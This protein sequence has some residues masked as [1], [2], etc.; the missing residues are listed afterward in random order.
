MAN[1]KLHGKMDFQ[2]LEISVENRA[3]SVRSGVDKDGHKW[4]TKMKGAHYGRIVAV[5][6]KGSD[7]EHVDVFV[8]V[9]P[10]KGSQVFIVHIN[11]ADTGK[12]DEDKGFLGFGSKKE[13]KAAFD[14][15]YDKAGRK[16][17]GGMT[18][19]DMS[20]FKQRLE[21]KSRQMIKSL[22]SDHLR[23]R[24]CH[25]FNPL[26]VYCRLRDCGLPVKAAKALGRFYEEKI[27]KKILAGPEAER[28]VKAFEA[29]EKAHIRGY[30]RKTGS[31]RVVFVK[32]HG[33]SRQTQ[34]PQNS[35][36]PLLDYK[37]TNELARIFQ[38]EFVK[39]E[40]K[41]PHGNQVVFEPRN[42]MH[43]SKMDTGRA[44]EYRCKRM[45]WI[46]D[47]IQSPDLIVQDGRDPDAR[48]FLKWYKGEPYLFVCRVKGNKFH[49]VTAYPLE[50]EVKL[51]A[52]LKQKR[53]YTRPGL[54]I[55]AM[56]EY[57]DL[58]PVIYVDLLKAR[59]RAHFPKV[60]GT[61]RGFNDEVVAQPNLSGKSPKKN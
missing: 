8:K 30:Y 3:G 38:R 27:Y 21:L 36:P 37:D 54:M 23:N 41:D 28:F 6:R 14:A 60:Q 53:L 29:L 4:R 24:F 11:H 1:H 49:S 33:D 39:A 47:V 22:D 35:P 44:D 50:S 58:L 20:T 7:G 59:V 48:L 34:F 32:E 40:I 25:R 9:K 10:D 42:F 55:K 16:L 12:F 43:I 18:E 51:R 13:A 17:Y 5:P 19:M 57:M 26:H 2:G 61:Q 45:M 46:K 52:L 15:N 31:G 56:G